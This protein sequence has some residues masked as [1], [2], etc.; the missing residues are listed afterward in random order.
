MAEVNINHTDILYSNINRIGE[1]I[2]K[3]ENIVSKENEEL[4]EK[5]ELMEKEL[6]EAKVS[7]NHFEQKYTELVHKCNQYEEVLR[8]YDSI[9]QD[10]IDNFNGIVNGIRIHYDEGFIRKNYKEM[11][12]SQSG[13]IPV[14][15][16]KNQVMKYI[17]NFIATV[18]HYSAKNNGITQD[19]ATIDRRDRKLSTRVYKAM[20]EYYKYRIIN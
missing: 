10:I 7:S 8:D 6:E 19:P 3:I 4:K 5:L 18:R 11:D 16:Y 12:F 1:S 20:R 13:E 9:S 2:N 17:S 14:Y 15:M